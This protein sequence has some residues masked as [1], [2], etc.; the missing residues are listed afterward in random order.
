MTKRAAHRREAG[1]PEGAE[2]RIDLGQAHAFA[3]SPC[4][5]DGVTIHFGNVAELLA[6]DRAAPAAVLADLAPR[7]PRVRQWVEPATRPATLL[8]LPRRSVLRQDGKHT[9]R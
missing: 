8:G 9:A 5:R 6:V 2:V 4:Q 1:Q 7:Q 3:S